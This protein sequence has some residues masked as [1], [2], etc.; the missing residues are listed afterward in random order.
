[1]FRI[2]ARQILAVA[3]LSALF[4]AGTIAVLDRLSNRLQP[5]GLRSLKRHLRSDGSCR[6]Y[7]RQNNIGNSRTL[8]ASVATAGSVRP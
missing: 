2:S 6:R 1:M 4:A 5:P 8:L 7:R 3:L